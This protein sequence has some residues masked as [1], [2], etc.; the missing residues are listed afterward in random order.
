VSART[1]APPWQTIYRITC[2]CGR[3]NKTTTGLAAA[4]RLAEGHDRAYHHG[5]PTATTA[6]AGR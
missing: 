4:R 5:Q 2:T 1:T 3:L 6:E